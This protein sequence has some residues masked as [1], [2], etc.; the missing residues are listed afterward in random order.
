MRCVISRASRCALSWGS[1]PEGCTR[2]LTKSRSPERGSSGTHCRR[3]VRR[4]PRSR[5][6]SAAEDVV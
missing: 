5:E 3:A 2:R 6:R 4:S 1:W